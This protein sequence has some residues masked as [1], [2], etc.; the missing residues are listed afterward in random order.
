MRLYVGGLPTDITARDV[1]GR[2]ASFGSVAGCEVVP[3]KGLDAADGACRGFAYVDFTPKDDASLA[4]CLSLVSGRSCGL[5]G[6]SRTVSR[7]LKL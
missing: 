7:C 3:A 1:E 2:F 6:R 4:R 5:C